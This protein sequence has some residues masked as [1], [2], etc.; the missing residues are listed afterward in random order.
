MHTYT[1]SCTYT[2]FPLIL[3]FLFFIL[4]LVKVNVILRK[5]C[6]SDLTWLV[7]WLLTY[8]S[9]YVLFIF[10]NNPKPNPDIESVLRKY[11]EHFCFV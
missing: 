9:K 4:C 7:A 8:A 3:V 10:Q 5:T 11:L 1:C 6:V 2:F